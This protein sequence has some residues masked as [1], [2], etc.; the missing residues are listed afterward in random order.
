MVKLQMESS[1]KLFLRNWINL[2]AEN[3]WF[4]HF[5]ET[6]EL[7]VVFSYKFQNKAETNLIAFIVSGKKEH[8]VDSFE[9]PSFNVEKHD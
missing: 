4:Y 2:V 7:D 8:I 5:V 6:L 9:M 3:L 1:N